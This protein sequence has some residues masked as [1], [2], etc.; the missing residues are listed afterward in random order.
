MENS[1][2]WQ[3]DPRNP[4]AGGGPGMGMGPSGYYNN[5]D[6]SKLDDEDDHDDSYDFGHMHTNMQQT[7]AEI[8]SWNN[9]NAYNDQR[10]YK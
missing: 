2:E 6:V 8:E 3:F 5:A 10:Y 9:N 7:Q 1:L 4:G